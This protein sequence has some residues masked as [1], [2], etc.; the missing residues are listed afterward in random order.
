[1]IGADGL[2]MLA[3]STALAVLFCGATLLVSLIYVTRVACR[4]RAD[5]PPARRILVLGMRLEAGKPGRDYR[6]RL[7]RAAALWARDRA[8]EIVILGGTTAAGQPSEA[9]AGAAFLRACGV[10][11]AAIQLED[12]S[13]HTLENLTLYRTHFTGGAGPVVLVTS[14]FHLARSSLLANGLGVAH[15]ACAAE[16]ARLPPLRHGPLMLFEAVLIHWYVTG[17]SFARLTGN[18]RIAGRIR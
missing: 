1:M 14:R 17:R 2:A 5:A 4:T 11:P 15:V 16:Q 18:R 9:V 10:A 3:L 8:A 6:A 7:E 12:R 13:R